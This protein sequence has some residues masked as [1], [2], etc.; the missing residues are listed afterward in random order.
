VV[1]AVG[2]AAGERLLDVGGGSAAYSI[3]FAKANPI[4]RKIIEWAPRKLGA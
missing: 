3:A 4:L 1:Q 2:P